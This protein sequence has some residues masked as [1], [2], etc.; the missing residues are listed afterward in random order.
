V[1]D[2]SAAGEEAT[3][4]SPGG[5]RRFKLLYER[6]ERR[7]AV[8]FFA[9]G[10][11]FDIVSVDRID[12]W[13]T[14]GQQVLY[15]SVIVLAL[16]QMFFEQGGPPLEPETLSVA[17][18]WYYRSRTALVSFCMG[19]LLNLYTIFY[20]K[21]ASLVVSFGFLAVLLALLF[22]NESDR[23][24]SLG[25]SFKFALLSLCTLSFFAYVVPVFVG[26]I[27]LFV[28]LFSILVGCLPLV[29]VSWWIRAHAPGRLHQARRQISVPLGLV[30]VGFLG[31]YYFRLIPPVPLS[32]PFIGVYHDV[33]K[34]EAGYRLSHQRPAW[35]F[36]ENG[37]QQFLAQGGDKIF[38]F[39]RIFSP[40][41]FSDQVTMRWFWK[42]DARGWTPQ[43][44]IPI[45]IVGGRK[46]GFRGYGVK[47]NYQF[48]DW[49]VQVETNDG[50]E[51]GRVYFTVEIAPVEQ[52]SFEVDID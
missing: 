12:S 50:R 29:G 33:E 14:I 43:D 22:A 37:D 15:L 32:I 4:R 17:R 51:I 44:S 47:S 35:R 40:T 11:V 1:S 39:F 45:N 7:I 25:L 3:G 36:W 52:R 24:K 34:T 19:T 20:F 21:S 5:I 2:P 26:S 10:F 13:F 42:D 23:F 9:G 38:V 27:G 16:T 8:V 49:K 18:R 30:L 28:F 48:G 31:L 46:E 41:R 6:H